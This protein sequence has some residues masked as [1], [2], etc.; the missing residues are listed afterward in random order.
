MANVQ[1]MAAYLLEFAAY[2]SDLL[3]KSHQPKLKNEKTHMLTKA[4]LFKN[5][6]RVSKSKGSPD[7]YG[8]RE[9]IHNL[10]IPNK[11]P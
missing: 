4:K 5:I 11:N 1:S 2:A 10:H 9:G 7:E 8:N 6:A 3:Q